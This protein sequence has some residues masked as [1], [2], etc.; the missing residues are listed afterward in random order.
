MD[1]GRKWAF[2]WPI[3]SSGNLYGQYQDHPPW[4]KSWLLQIGR[5]LRHVSIKTKGWPALYLGFDACRWRLEGGSRRSIHG[6]EHDVP[7]DWTFPKNNPLYD[8]LDSIPR[9]DEGMYD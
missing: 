8:G 3:L 5:L 9:G 2:D 7:P 4:Q 1:D 6:T